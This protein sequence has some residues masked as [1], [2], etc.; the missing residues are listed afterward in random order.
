MAAKK[1]GINLYSL[2]DFTQTESDYRE[3]LKKVKNI[4]Y[5]GVQIS[6]IKGLEPEQIAEITK[7]YGLPIAATHLSWDMFRDDLPRAIEIQKLYDCPNAATGGLPNDYFSLEG[8]ER[9][10][11]EV[12]TVIE[13]LKRE[14]MNFS[15]H[16]HNHEFARYDGR[17]WYERVHTGSEKLGLNFEIDTY[18]VQAGGADPVA[19]INRSAGRIPLLHAKDMIVMPTRE[20]RFAPVGSG[21]LEWDAVFAASEKAGVEWYLVEEDTFYD[22]DPFDD[23]AKSCAFLKE[24]LG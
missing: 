21:N 13:G 4:G 11:K 24:K 8:A 19:W 6:G 14:G 2:R 22:A 7:E 3:T 9:F 20:Q 12:G 15:Y 18:W 5:D 23:V 16:N 10:L 17:T 1:I